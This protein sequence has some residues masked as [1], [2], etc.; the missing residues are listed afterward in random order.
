MRN[1][2]T[3]VCGP[4]ETGTGTIHHNAVK[5]QQYLDV[6]VIFGLLAARCLLRMVI[7]DWTHKHSSFVSAC[8]EKKNK[9]AFCV[10][11][12]LSITVVAG[13]SQHQRHIPFAHFLN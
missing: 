2:I 4:S 7:G 10:C 9:E 1:H 13:S 3:S 11:S 5:Y 8:A 6:D 12:H